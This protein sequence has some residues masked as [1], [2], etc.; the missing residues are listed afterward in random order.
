MFRWL[1]VGV[2]LSFMAGPVFAQVF[3]CRDA[4]GRLYA[5]DNLQAL[6]ESCRAQ[7][8]QLPE[9]PAGNLNYVPGGAD[10]AGSSRDFDRTVMQ[11][12]QELAQRQQRE[13]ALLKR[14][15]E[16]VAQYREAETQKWTARKDMTTRSK[17][18]YEE[19]QQKQLTLLKEKEDI[20]AELNRGRYSADC[21]EQVVR[22][23][24]ALSCK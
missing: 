13:Q 17:G 18:V 16:V 7:V 24:E 19:A 15:R 1:I 2:L 12:T 4:T 6:P 21:R 23:L 3:T 9:G 11:A 20:L 8:K 5:G 10:R 14:T 22:E